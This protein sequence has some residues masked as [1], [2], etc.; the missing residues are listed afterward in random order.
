M[1]DTTGFDR[2]TVGV[3]VPEV[4]ALRPRRRRRLLGGETVLGARWLAIGLGLVLAAGAAAW[5]GTHRERVVR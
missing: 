2:T 1:S 5:L 3:D 4:G